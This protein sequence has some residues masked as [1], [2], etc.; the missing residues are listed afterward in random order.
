[1][2]RATKLANFENEL[3]QATVYLPRASATLLLLRFPLGRFVGHTGENSVALNDG[4]SLD[5]RV[6]S[7][8]AKHLLSNELKHF[9]F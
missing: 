9:F 3:S 4:R 8:G 2:Y 7:G 6:D 5:P 1:M